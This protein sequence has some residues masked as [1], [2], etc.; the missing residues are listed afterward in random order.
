MTVG[1]TLATVW[2]TSG[3]S[4]YGSFIITVVNNGGGQLNNVA[5]EYYTGTAWVSAGSVAGL[6]PLNGGGTATVTVLS[7]SR[8]TLRIRLSATATIDVTLTVTPLETQTGAFLQATL[9]SPVLTTPLVLGKVSLR[10]AATVAESVSGLLLGGGTSASPDVTSVADG[11]FIEFRC[12]S[13]AASGDN[14]LLYMRYELNGNDGQ[15][16][17]GGGECLRALT[18]LT[19][20][21][22][23]AH[24]GHV[25]M[26]IS[27]TGYITGL[28]AGARSTLQIDNSAVPAGGTYYGHLAEIFSDGTS[29]SIAAVTKH[30]VFGIAA[31]GNATGAATVLNALSFDGVSA[32]D[33][34]KMISS[35]SLGEL[36]SGTVGIACLINGTRYYI[37]A[38]A[39]D[40]WN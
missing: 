18:V 11:K 10:T 16:S 20:E 15:A 24:G 37:P 19:A 7:V 39:V 8:D 36:P 28:G 9:A 33:T 12:K 13:I 1:T 40:Q 3:L 21:N 31:S 38:V 4:K 27:S 14:R 5:F 26:F 25:G 29:S 35:V 34:T 17:S 22:G 2:Q 30:A 32:G 6:Y 23:T